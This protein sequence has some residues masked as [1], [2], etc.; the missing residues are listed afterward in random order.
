MEGVGF[1]KKALHRAALL[2]LISVLACGVL[3]TT[4]AEDDITGEVPYTVEYYSFNDKV[5]TSGLVLSYF[6]QTYKA[7]AGQGTSKPLAG[8]GLS[9]AAR[10][11]YDT[12]AEGVQEI[13]AGK[14]SS[15]E[16]SFPFGDLY[17]KLSFTAEE[18]G[19]EALISGNKITDEAL[20]AFNAYMDDANMVRLAMHAIRAD[21]PYELYWMANDLYWG[22]GRSYSYTYNK[23][24]KTITFSGTLKVM[25][26]VAPAYSTTGAVST[27]VNTAYG[28]AAQAAA[29]KA[30]EIVKKNAGLSNYAKLKAYKDAI[31]D[32]V[33]Y[34]YAAA[35]GATGLDGAYQ[36]IWVF[37]GDDSTNVVCEGYAKAF[38]YLCDHSSWQGSVSVLLVAG[39]MDGGGHAWNLVR[40]P[41]GY[42]YLVDV[43]NCDEGMVGYSNG[44]FMVGYETEDNGTYYYRSNGELIPY[45]YGSEI[46]QLFKANDLSVNETDYDPD[47]PDPTP[48]SATPTPTPVPATPTPT[49]VPATPTPTP[50]PATPTPTPKPARV[51]G[52]ANGDGEF[53]LDDIMLMID[54]YVGLA[55][56]D[57]IFLSNCDLDNDGIQCDLSDIML[58]IDYYCQ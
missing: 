8:N 1:M 51:P 41:D 34:N 37:D 15:T 40:M 12:L 57:S 17:D 7:L 23:S 45:R 52:D 5:K 30:L 48:V 20:Q 46:T 2:L 56:A 3:F 21:Y 43:T 29:A 19:V 36:M 32:L 16:F 53:E 55:G 11:I 50:V 22:I 31:C 38:K 28:Q 25:P 42:N 4:Q 10:K 58:A 35:G 9:G 47:Q 49:P 44:L 27:S 33:S 6:N 24:T 14:R 18:L 39:T 26:Q 54:Y 13:A